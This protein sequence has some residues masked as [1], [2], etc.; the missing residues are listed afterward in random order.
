MRPN[1]PIINYRAPGCAT[2]HRAPQ[3]FS[4]IPSTGANRAELSYFFSGNVSVSLIGLWVRAA[5]SRDGTL[6]ADPSGPDWY[7]NFT[8]SDGAGGSELGS[9]LP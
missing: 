8:D 1:V 2:A 4:S 5:T 9:V 6:R 3:N 7:G